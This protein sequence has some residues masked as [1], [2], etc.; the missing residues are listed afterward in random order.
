MDTVTTHRLRLFGDV[1]WHGAG[2]V[3][4]FRPERRFQLLALLACR[5]DWG[6]REQLAEQL[7]PE[8]TPADAKRNLRKV[9][10]QASWLAAA[11]PLAPPLELQGDRLRWAPASDL[12]DFL[13]A[14]DAGWHAQAVQA[15]RPGLLDGMKAGLGEAA[16]DWL[17]RQRAW[18]EQC[19]HQAVQHWLAAL[20]HDPAATADA[21]ELVLA[22][23]PLHEATLRALLRACTV[24]G[25]PARAQRAQQR[26]AHHLQQ[27]LGLAPAPD[28]AAAA[29]SH[30]PLVPSAM[31]GVAP[32]AV[33]RII[34]AA[35]DVVAAPGSSRRCCSG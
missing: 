18:L 23:D 1:S 25:E 34:E 4:P 5:C 3:L 19:W 28:L 14:C 26:H 2:R 6:T 20:A 13:H 32:A 24:L 21:A 10:L 8:R 35:M 16:L 33:H 12:A 27:E 9:I 29:P 30:A 7:W 11:L 17:A 15:Y 31:P 22:R